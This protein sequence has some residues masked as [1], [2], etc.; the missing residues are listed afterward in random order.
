MGF[1]R[2]IKTPNLNYYSRYKYCQ[3][4]KYRMEALALVSAQ[5]FGGE[6]KIDVFLRPSFLTQKLGIGLK[7]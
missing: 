4:K 5:G 7:F 6:K 1:Y 3:K 2:Y